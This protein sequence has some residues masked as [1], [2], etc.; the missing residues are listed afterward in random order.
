MY[1]P[2]TEKSIPVMNLLK[3]LYL[4]E[5]DIDS[6]EVFE[7]LVNM[8]YQDKDY[9]FISEM[10]KITFVVKTKKNFGYRIYWLTSNRN[11]S[12]GS[13][14][15]KR[16]CEFEIKTDKTLGHGTLPP[17]R[18]RDDPAFHYYNVGQSKIATNNRIY[19][20]LVKV[21]TDCLLPEDYAE[22]TSY[23]QDQKILD[24]EQIKATC[25]LMGGPL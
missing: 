5:L 1:L 20:G 15:C 19:D 10:K 2:L 11:R 14:K 4:N 6:Q 23:N 16:G 25:D 13:V 9:N 18:H 17:S 8:K 12:I 3:D 21:L 7:R 22:D 24:D